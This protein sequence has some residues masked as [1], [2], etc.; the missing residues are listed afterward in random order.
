MPFSVPAL[1]RSSAL[2]VSL[3]ITPVLHANPAGSGSGSN[4]GSNPA[5]T[6]GAKH[7][8]AKKLASADAQQDGE[9]ANFGQWHEV[10]AF[11]DDMVAR[12]GFDRAALNRVF[13]K[14][15]YI[16]SAITLMKPAPA[17][18]PKN[19]TAYRLRFVEP[20]RIN[21][22]MQFWNKYEGELTRAEI[23]YGVPAEIIVAIIGVET[24]YGSNTGNFRVMDAI[25]TLAFDYP[26]T[27]NR[28]ARMQFFR[29]ELENTLLFA[30][31]SHIDPFSLLGSYAGAIGL[32]QFMPSSIRQYAVD[33][34]GDGKIDLRN[35]P[36][37]AIGSVA[38]FLSVHGWRRG[39]PLVYPVK[40]PADD[41][42][43]QTWQPLLDKGL[44]ATYSLDD[45][46]A[47]GIVPT[48]DIPAASKADIN[49]AG[50]ADTAN[51]INTGSDVKYGLIDLQNGNGPTEY[52][53]G[54][55]NFFAITKYNRSYFYAMSVIDLSRAI[56]AAKEQ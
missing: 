40:A 25:T 27:P 44:E 22:G 29:G 55:D 32:P 16:D 31:E 20:V 9:F 7:K 5:K 35:S 2:I 39:L 13:S 3:A 12:D 48:A 6:A 33:F 8:A 23:D 17:G 42:A 24:V 4:S 28:D 34:D 50:A 51:T 11:I 37:D 46:K 45:I 18:R 36:V 49:A 30:R 52:W 43:A 14:T 10:A 21:A 1:L 53:L 47:A 26:D 41:A 15:R 56:R 54:S 38:H 19:W